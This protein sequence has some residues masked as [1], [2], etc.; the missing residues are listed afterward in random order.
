MFDYNVYDL[1][2][3]IVVFWEVVQIFSVGKLLSCLG[4]Y[5]CLNIKNDVYKYVLFI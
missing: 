2:C 4:K 3:K 1:K 5:F